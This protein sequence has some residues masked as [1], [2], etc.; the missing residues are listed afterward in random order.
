M[1]LRINNSSQSKLES[2]TSF[3]V[4]IYPL[5]FGYT[6]IFPLITF[7][8]VIVLITMIY[9]VALSKG[10]IINEQA[11][12]CTVVLVVVRVSASFFENVNL[13]DS[14]GTGARL[15]ML[16]CFIVILKPYFNMRKGKKYLEVVGLIVAVYA[17]MQII[18]AR[19]GIYLTAYLPFLNSI[20]D[21][22][23]EVLQKAMYGIAFRPTSILGEPAELGGYL[24]LP[25]AINLFDDLRNKG[26]LKKSIFFSIAIV[27]TMS[28]T[29]IA[30]FLL[31]W[32]IFVFKG[33]NIR[34]KDVLVATLIIG[35]CTAFFVSGMWKF[36]V[37]RTFESYGGEGIKGILLNTHY[38]DI[39]GIYAEKN[40]IINILFGNGMSEPSGFLPGVFRLY[41]YFGIVGIVI[42]IIWLFDLYK[43]GSDMQR[44]LM[45]VW[46]IMN[47]GGAYIL[48]SF[49]LP[50]TLFLDAKDDDGKIEIDN[51]KE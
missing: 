5:I 6:S 44:Y 2:W 49:A 4:V 16:Y 42:F 50:Y 3:L 18:A 31:E 33:K 7:G 17:F 20:R 9:I 43:K 19:F 13:A 37:K 23:G 24:A 40:G 36:F 46:L 51:N 14:L 30:L 41:Y 48:G 39:A 34:N 1:V 26:W 12:I 47:V 27:L 25:L 32:T 38:K 21:V 28:S 22:N 29:G 45:L 10:R 15:A 8:E 35:G 11:L